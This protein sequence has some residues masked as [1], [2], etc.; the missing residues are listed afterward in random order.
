MRVVYDL[1]ACQTDSRDRGIGRYAY[2]LVQAMLELSAETGGVDAIVALDGTDP[3][4]RL[5]ELR[6]NLRHEEFKAA[7]AVYSYPRRPSATRDQ[8][9]GHAETAARL[10]GRFYESLAPDALL[11]LS[12]FETNSNYTTEI[13]W[14]NSFSVPTVVV[15]YDVIPLIYPDKYLPPDRPISDWYKKKCAT[16]SKFDHF[17]AISQATRN[18]LIEHLDIPAERISVIGAGL[19]Q[20]FLKLIE[21]AAP[22][23]NALLKKLDIDEPFVLVGSNLDWRKNTLGALEAFARLPAAITKRHLMVL[24]Q[25]GDEIHAALS[26]P[27]KSIARRVRILGKV[28][29]AVL[30]TLYRRCELFFFPSYYEG[31]GLPVL[32]AMAFGAAVLSSN[33]G[34]LPELVCRQDCLFDP[35]DADAMVEKLGSVLSSTVMRDSL[36]DGVRERAQTYAWRDCAEKALQAIS[37]VVKSAPD[38]D[39]SRPQRGQMMI[40]SSDVPT[41]VDFLATTPEPSDFVKFEDGIRAAA[42][43]GN[44]RILVDVTTVAIEDARTGIQRVVRNFARGLAEVAEKEGF[45]LQLVRWTA[46]GVLYANSYARESLGLAFG[47]ED[48]PF[49]ARV[50]DLLFMVDSSWNNPERFDSLNK[51]IWEK[52]GEVVWMVY[53]LIPLLFPRTC[54]PGMPIAFNYWLRHAVARADGFVCISRSTLNDLERYIDTHGGYQQRP[55]TRFVHLG[56]DLDPHLANSPTAEL[57]ATMRGIASS[58]FLLAIGTVEPRKDHATILRAFE[59]LWAAG[60]TYALVIVGKQG[61]NVSALAKKI[62][63]H[64]EFNRRLFWFENL[65][66]Q[67]LSFLLQKASALIQASLSEGFGLPIVEAG[68][69]GVPLL[70]SDIPVFHE[71]A[72]STARYFP[73][74]EASGLAKLIADGFKNGFYR[75]PPGEIVTKTWRDVSVELARNLLMLFPNDA[76]KI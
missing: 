6:N 29:D 10:R 57:A 28:S 54:D 34:S 9:P 40:E 26:G 8:E 45:D 24:T 15:A 67:N 51:A 48:R 27:L 75:P 11:Q 20:K 43:Q 69:R 64:K 21:N 35:H 30:A 46:N 62:R 42:A 7:T 70:L 5:R 49:E 72:G 33:R 74:G 3:P 55:W 52:G 44:R 53:D 63:Q 76:L 50:N 16:F 65:C 37:G 1:Q 4:D 68:A 56:S 36:R 41:W 23:E 39:M 13:I 32:E 60:A 14:R 58:P 17:L 61:W 31:F 47:G 22:D 2:N 38:K 18:D 73:S 71:V 12:H 25:V 59:A 66:D 19:D